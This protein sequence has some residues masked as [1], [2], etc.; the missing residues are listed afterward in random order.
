MELRSLPIARGD[1]Q[2]LPDQCEQPVVAGASA[3]ASD[4][5]S[6]SIRSSEPGAEPADTDRQWG[7]DQGVAAL[8]GEMEEGSEGYGKVLKN[9]DS[10]GPVRGSSQIHIIL[11]LDTGTG[12]DRSLSP[13]SN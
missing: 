3:G 12:T 6:N 5:D 4:S 11:A 8:D 10:E 1:S 9:E 2:S 7:D 13:M